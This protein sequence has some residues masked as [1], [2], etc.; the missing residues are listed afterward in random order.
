[1]SKSSPRLVTQRSQASQA[2]RARCVRVSVSHN[3]THHRQH[4]QLAQYFD[5]QLVLRQ[6]EADI[7]RRDWNRDVNGFR[8]T[9]QVPQLLADPTEWKP[10]FVIYTNFTCMCRANI[11]HVS[12]TSTGQM[13]SCR[14]ALPARTTRT[15]D[16]VPLHCS[17]FL[18]KTSQYVHPPV[19]PFGLL[20]TS[21]MFCMALSSALLH[22]QPTNPVVRLSVLREWMHAET[23]W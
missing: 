17:A 13:P 16:V 3:G 23:R 6:Q 4:A 8:S 9:A 14:I 10:G 7:A 18:A 2:T 19:P 11:P 22:G 12:G 15:A 1:M 20:T 21:S 5:E